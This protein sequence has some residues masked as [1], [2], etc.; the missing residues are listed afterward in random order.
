MRAEAYHTPMGEIHYWV[1]DAGED[2]PCLAMLPGLTADHRLFDRQTQALGG[3]YRCLVWDAPAH[4]ASRPFS[5]DFYMDELTGWLHEI[6]IKEK[7]DRPVLVGQSMGGYIAQAYIKRYP[8][9]VRGFVSVDSAPLSRSYFSGWELAMLKHA[10]W[11][12][13]PI[14]WGLLQKLGSMGTAQS[15]YGRGLMADMMKAYTPKE[16]CRL[17]AHGYRLLSL[18]VTA[19]GDSE[20]DCPSLLLCG[21]KD[22]AGSSRRYNRAWARR[23][24][25]RLVWLKGAGHNSNTDAP[26]E[27]N[28]LLQDFETNLKTP[29]QG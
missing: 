2:R 11:L 22:G 1:G 20:P 17:A 5:L 19:H 16:Y 27:V 14:P 4:G 8:G 28:R 21:E 6:F 10:Y 25:H 12:Y 3:I 9:T 15:P 18:A 26:E 13:R 7:F 24:G 29:V 23:A